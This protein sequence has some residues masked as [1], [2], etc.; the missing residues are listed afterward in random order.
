M[1]DLD[2]FS[3]FVTR[4]DCQGTEGA[5]DHVT[6]EVLPDLVWLYGRLTTWL[7]RSLLVQL[8][9]DRFG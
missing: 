4:E 9:Q 2:W 3:W 1:K 5:R 8:V 6:A 7:Q